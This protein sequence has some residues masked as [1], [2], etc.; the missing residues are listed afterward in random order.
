MYCCCSS[1]NENSGVRAV[2]RD[3]EQKLLGSTITKE[4]E[5]F[6]VFASLGQI[7]DIYHFNRPAFRVSMFGLFSSYD[8]V[9]KVGSTFRQMLPYPI[10]SCALNTRN[11]RDCI[12]SAGCRELDR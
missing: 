5:M 1:L 9:F 11:C 12:V 4:F 8:F 10:D 2:V 7:Y 3:T 6:E